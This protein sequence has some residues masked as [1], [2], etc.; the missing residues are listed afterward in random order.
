MNHQASPSRSTIK[1]SDQLLA[2][3]RFGLSLAANKYTAKA[4]AIGIAAIPITLIQP[5]AA[6]KLGANRAANTVPE[7]PAPAMPSAVP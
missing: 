3:G 7:L 2:D 6:A 1:Y 5:N 4:M